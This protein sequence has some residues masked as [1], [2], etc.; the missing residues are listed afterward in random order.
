MWRRALIAYSKPS[1]MHKCPAGDGTLPNKR[2]RL[3]YGARA[4]Q[5]QEAAATQALVDT[6]MELWSYTSRAPGPELGDSLPCS[7][8]C[9]ARTASCTGHTS[10]S[11]TFV[12]CC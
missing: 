10:R 3:A 6:P 4:S 1:I 12:F 11:W 8:A 5:G 9:L 2:Q 7:G